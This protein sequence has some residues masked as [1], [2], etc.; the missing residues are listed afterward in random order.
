M[1]ISLVLMDRM[2]SRRQSS[3]KII[4][5]PLLGSV[6]TIHST[7]RAPRT[8]DDEQLD[9]GD[10]EGRYDRMEDRMDYEDGGEFRETVNI[11]DL[12]LGRAPEPVSTNGEVCGSNSHCERY[13]LS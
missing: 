12:S 2:E 8:L 7:S 5:S 1:P 3:T 13:Y 9:S 4:C 6:L 11:M 10:D